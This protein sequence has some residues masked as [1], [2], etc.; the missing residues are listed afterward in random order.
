MFVVGQGKGGGDDVSDFAGAGG[1]VLQGA[2][3]LGEQGESTFAEA[4]Q[5]AQQRVVGPVV[6]VQ[7]LGSDGLF[8]RGMHP[9]AGPLVAAVGQ[10]GQ[11]LGSGG[12]EDAEGV[13]AGA[14]QVVG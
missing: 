14:G 11:S 13:L 2:P 10:G 8:D 3:T 5:T 1:Q 12:V 6:R 7:P 4:A 9:D